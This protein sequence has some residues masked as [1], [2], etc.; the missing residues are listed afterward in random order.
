MTRTN[1]GARGGPDEALAAEIAC[2]L[3]NGSRQVTLEQIDAELRAI[4]YRLDRSGDCP[5][6]NRYTSG[7]RAGGSTSSE[8]RTIEHRRARCRPGGPP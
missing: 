2:K 5:S 3:A 7:P 4:G 6:L 8:R 1:P